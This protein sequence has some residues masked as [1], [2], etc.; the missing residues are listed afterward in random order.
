M[1]NGKQQIVHVNL[2]AFCWCAGQGMYQALFTCRDVDLQVQVDSD[3]DSSCDEL[4][5]DDQYHG[6]P[7]S[8][9]QLIKAGFCT[10]QGARVS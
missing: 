5:R 1:A 3:M 10:K 4:E 8:T 7:H 6:Q 2:P 9:S